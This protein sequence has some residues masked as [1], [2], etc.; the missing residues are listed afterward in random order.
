MTSY[1]FLESQSPQRRATSHVAPHRAVII[2]TASVTV[3]PRIPA[4]KPVQ[5]TTSLRRNIQKILCS[6]VPQFSEV[7]YMPPSRAAGPPENVDHGSF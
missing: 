7:G 6:P 2:T 1:S 5:R 4:M 3:L